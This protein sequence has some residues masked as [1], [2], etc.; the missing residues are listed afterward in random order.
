MGPKFPSTFQPR[1]TLTDNGTLE[2]RNGDTVTLMGWLLARQA[3][4]VGDVLKADDT[5][6]TDGPSTIVINSGGNLFATDETT[7]DLSNLTLNS[8]STRRS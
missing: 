3:I 2:L 1:Q 7:F 5:T 6:F 8:G 4:T